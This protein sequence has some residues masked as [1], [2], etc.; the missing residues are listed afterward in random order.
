MANARRVVNSSPY[1]RVGIVACPWFQSSPIEYESL[2]ERD[3]VRL[4]LLDLRV[5]SIAH[6]PFKVDLGNS[7]TYTPDFLVTG[8]HLRLVVEVKPEERARTPQ[9]VEAHNRAKERLRAQGYDF[10]VATEK[11]IRA[12]KRHDKAA[13]LLRHARSHLPLTVVNETIRISQQ[14]RDG[15]RISA[16]ASRAGVPISTVLYLIGRR[17]LRINQMLDFS[18]SQPV[19]PNGGEHGHL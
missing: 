17:R 15:I 10:I 5:C 9:I 2:L 3:F 16:L 13:V 6:Q 1:R 11:L 18:P 19:Y 8:T 4:A 7:R 12:N 14:F